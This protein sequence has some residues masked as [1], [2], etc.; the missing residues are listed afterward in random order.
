VPGNI[1][2]VREAA[3]TALQS[4]L[5]MKLFETHATGENFT[6]HGE[7]AAKDIAKKL[8]EYWKEYGELSFAE[9]L[10]KV[11]TN[12]KADDQMQRDAAFNISHLSDDLE[13]GWRHM[14]EFA[15]NREK[16]NPAVEK[17]S[18]PTAAEA[19]LAVMDA[20][21]SHVG[22]DNNDNYDY[23]RIKVENH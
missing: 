4:I 22:K 9:R 16:P 6:Q 11:L 18:K 10:M 13:F 23:G 20:E 17:L 2:S 12:A 14:D 8:R 3:P 19:I 21:L 1:L 5:R 7:K 15:K